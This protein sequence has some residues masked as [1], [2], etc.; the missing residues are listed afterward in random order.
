MSLQL[1][2]ST[3]HW[4]HFDV[5]D[6]WRCWAFQLLFRL[7]ITS[8]KMDRSDAA[9]LA[10]EEDEDE[11]MRMQVRNPQPSLRSVLC[12]DGFSM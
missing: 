7:Q 12:F 8:R 11:L 3:L 2:M 10:G 5:S 1:P 4:R 6:S 9:G